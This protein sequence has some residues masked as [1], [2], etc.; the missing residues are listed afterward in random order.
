MVGV[1]ELIVMMF[2]RNYQSSYHR[3]I[4]II[5]HF[6]LVRVLSI[7]TQLCQQ[8]LQNIRFNCLVNSRE[9]HPQFNQHRLQ[10]L[11]HHQHQFHVLVRNTMCLIH[12]WK[13]RVSSD[14]RIVIMSKGHLLLTH[15]KNFTSVYVILE[16]IQLKVV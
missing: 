4:P 2:I 16:H 14:M 6:M 7:L 3:E 11:H 13:H 5:T 8:I 15:L 9:Q 10:H 1:Q 12:H